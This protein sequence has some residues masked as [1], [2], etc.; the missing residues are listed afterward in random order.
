MSE[1][2]RKRKWVKRVALLLLAAAVM[3]TLGSQRPRL[4]GSLGVIAAQVRVGMSQD[5]AIA[6]IRT[7]YQ[8]RPK[9]DI[10]RLYADGRT[11]DERSFGRYFDWAFDDFPPADQVAWAELDIDDDNGRDLIVTFGPGG[12]VTSVRLKSDSAWEEWRY[13]LSR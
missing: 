5:E 2:A 6:L 1:I 7:S 8:E 12:V 9:Y 4:P 11:H 3:C 10:P 13:N